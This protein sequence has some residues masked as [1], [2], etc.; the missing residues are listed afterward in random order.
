[1]EEISKQE[2]SKQKEN[3]KNNNSKNNNNKKKYVIIGILMIFIVIPMIIT[4]FTHN[5]HFGKRIVHENNYYAYLTELNPNFTREEITFSSNEQQMLGGAFHY[6]E[7]SGNPKGLI[8]WVHGMGVNYENYLG[9]IEWLTRQGYTVFSYNNTGVDTSEGEDLKG[10]IQAPIDLKH[11][12]E[13]VNSLEIYNDIPN[14][15]I[16]HSWGGFSVATVSM[17]GIPREVDGIVTLAGFWRNINVIEDIAKYYVG[18]VVTLLVPYLTFYERC[19]FGEYSYLNGV[20]G[21]QSTTAEVMIIHSKDDIIVSFDNNFMYYKS[22]F[23]NDERFTFVGYDTAGH[24]LSINK[25][26]Y[27]RIHDIMHHQIELEQTDSHYIELEQERLNL[28]TDFNYD[29]MDKILDFC[30]NIV[31]NY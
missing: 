20:E 24:K 25:A 18:D 5:Y 16:G 28:I 1:M 4:Y 27:D 23:E 10:L 7:D 11:A 15:L 26:S 13:Y 14:I 2:I 8:I 22:F 30:N 3:N 12:L 21:L 29:V 31:L 19:L 9:E 6:Q 17:L